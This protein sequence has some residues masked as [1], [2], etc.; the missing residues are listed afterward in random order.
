MPFNYYTTSVVT[1]HSITSEPMSGNGLGQI[2]SYFDIP[3]IPVMHADVIVWGVGLV[4]FRIEKP[5]RQPRKPKVAKI[6]ALI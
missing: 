6:Y 2:T 1:Y 5:P 3:S 4:V